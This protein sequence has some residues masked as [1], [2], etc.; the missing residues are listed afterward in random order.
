MK[1]QL[2][3]QLFK[4]Y[5]TP[6]EAE[7]IRAEVKE[8]RPRMYLILEDWPWLEVR[9]LTALRSA[10]FVEWLKGRGMKFKEIGGKR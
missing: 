2:L 5:L 9:G 10:A 1:G 3:L 4:P 6:F 7:E 8:L